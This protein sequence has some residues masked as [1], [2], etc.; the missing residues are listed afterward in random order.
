MSAETEGE[1]GARGFR[2]ASIRRTEL[3][4]KIKRRPWKKSLT[5]LSTKD[6]SLG[7]ESVLWGAYKQHRSEPPEVTLSAVWRTAWTD[8]GPFH[9]LVLRPQGEFQNGSPKECPQKNRT[10]TSFT[11][12]EQDDLVLQGEVGEVGDA[13]GPL[14]EGE[15]LLV[16]GVTYVSHGVICL[17]GDEAPGGRSWD[18][19]TPLPPPAAPGR[20]EPGGGPDHLPS[21]PC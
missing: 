6:V 19:R 4:L 14:D 17:E 10:P 18:S 8:H 7:D 16:G 12:P 11:C 13:L 20:W 1:P 9:L 5:P 3:S 2:G 21:S 15:Q